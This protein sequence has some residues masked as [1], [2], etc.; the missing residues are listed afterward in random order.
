MDTFEAIKNRRSIRKFKADPVDDETLEKVLEAGRL[1][2]SWANT[3]CWRFIVIR[4]QAAKDALADAIIAN[5]TLGRNPAAGGIRTAPVVIAACAEKEVSGYFSGKAA[6]DKGDYW[7]MFDVALALENMMIAA[8]SLGLGMVHIGLFDPGVVG[9]ILGIPDNV[10][11]VELTPLGY[12]E[13]QPNPRPRKELSEIVYYEKY[14]QTKA[15]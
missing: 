11:L 5:P 1:A 15:L 2:P 13:F 7:F 12:P 8:T 3:Q 10:N 4:D 6:T 14:G 9:G